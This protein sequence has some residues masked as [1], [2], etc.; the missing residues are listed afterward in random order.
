MHQILPIARGCCGILSIG[1]SLSL[2]QPP[3][4]FKGVF[5]LATDEQLKSL[6]YVVLGAEKVPQELFAFME[7][8][9]GR[10]VREGYGITECSPVVTLTRP[11]KPRKGVGQ[12]LPG[13]DLCIVS[14]ETREVML[15]GQEGEICIHGT[16]V[17]KGYIGTDKNPFIELDGRRWAIFQEISDVLET[18]GDLFFYLAALNDL[19]KS[20][21]RWSV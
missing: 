17:F 5:N 3:P 4:S 1:K 19:S 8:G 9:G 18:D 10:D 7:K 21:A 12:P 15:P 16:N 20:A 14:P 6:R 13:V 11:K 2:F